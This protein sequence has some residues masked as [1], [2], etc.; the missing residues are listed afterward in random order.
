MSRA[1]QDPPTLRRRFIPPPEP[2]PCCIT[3]SA[4][5]GMWVRV[6]PDAIFAVRDAIHAGVRPGPRITSARRW[7]TANGGHGWPVGIEVDGADAIRQAARAEIKAGAILIKLM[8]SGGV[9]GPGLGPATE[10]FSQEEIAVA[11]RAAHGV[12]LT[13]A[14]LRTDKEASEAR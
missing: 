14:A 7:L 10:Q 6:G 9:I 13:V 3:G 4:R 11:A 1:T 12:G 2:R 5:L 8:A